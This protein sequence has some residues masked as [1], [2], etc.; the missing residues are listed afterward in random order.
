MQ[1]RE[2]TLRHIFGVDTPVIGMVHL[3]PLPGSPGWQGDLDEVIA[4]AVA[5]ALALERGG[6]HGLIVENFA[7]VPYRVGQ[8]G[9]ET[10]A[11]MARVA[12][13]IRRAVRLPLGVNVQFNDFRSELAVAIATGAAFIRVEAFVDTVYSGQGVVYPCSSELRRW[14]AWLGAQAVAIF[15]DL[16]VKHTVPL[17]NAT[18]EFSAREARE[19]G[20]AAV[21]ITGS[22]TGSAPRAEDVVRAREL[23]RLPVLVGSGVSLATAPELL[24]VADGVIVG[25]AFKH[26]GRVE[27]P[28]SEEAVRAFMSLAG[29]LP[30]KP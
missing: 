19:A 9:P 1:V 18:L 23:A 20:A 27:A 11:A 2:S 10:A 15:A 28:V 7:D 16:Q 30:R 25:T 21:I 8:N 3:K 24:P 22:A 17:P 12:A 26:G 13:E 29:G 14:H 5:D 6:V 4:C